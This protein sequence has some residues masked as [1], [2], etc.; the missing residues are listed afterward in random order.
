MTVFR[1]LLIT[2]LLFVITPSFAAIHPT[3]A[4]PPK[5]P[6]QEAVLLPNNT[7]LEGETRDEFY[8]LTKQEAVHMLAER[9]RVAFAKKQAEQKKINEQIKVTEAAIAR[10]KV[11]K[12]QAVEINLIP[13]KP[14]PAVSNTTEAPKE[15]VSSDAKKAEQ[16]LPATHAKLSP[17]IV[18][19]A[20][21]QIS[22][23]GAMYQAEVPKHFV[24][25]TLQI[26]NASDLARFTTNTKAP[27][28]KTS[29]NQSRHIKATTRKWRRSALNHHQAIAPKQKQIGQ[30]K[31][32]L[33][34]KIAYRQHRALHVS[35]QKMTPFRHAVIKQVRPLMA[36]NHHPLRYRMTVHQKKGIK[37]VNTKVTVRTVRIHQKTW[38]VKTNPQQ[39]VAFKKK[40]INATM[41][42]PKVALKKIRL[43]LTMRHPKTSIN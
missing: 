5:K 11:L 6:V 18:A 39:D 28:L 24:D 21:K 9:K 10:A 4:K 13:T 27:K 2:T 1:T 12:G 14:T 3:K 7:L 17:T 30:K 41:S 25:H 40:K 29:Q 19:D 26:H 35:I 34:A 33:N 20:Q 22:Q 8:V 42:Q 16:I 32:A 15:I 36:S 31:K 38:Q 37:L 43:K 23:R